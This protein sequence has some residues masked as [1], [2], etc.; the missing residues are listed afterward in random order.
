MVQLYLFPS[1]VRLIY[2]L[3]DLYL[4]DVGQVMVMVVQSIF[5]VFMQLSSNHSVLIVKQILG[6]VSLFLPKSLII[7]KQLV[8]I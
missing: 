2:L 5:M 6:E 4:G 3:S 8:A 7:V 1:L